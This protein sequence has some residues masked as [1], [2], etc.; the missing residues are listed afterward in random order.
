[1]TIGFEQNYTVSEGVGSFL[2]CFRVF[3]PPD[4]Q[5]LTLSVDLVVNTVEGSASN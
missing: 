3:N 2:A 4:D 1:M 5:E